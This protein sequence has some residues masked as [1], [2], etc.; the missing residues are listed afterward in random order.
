MPRPPFSPVDPLDHEILGEK[1]AA[2]GRLG[3]GLEKALAELRTF[4]A[5][6]GQPAAAEPVDAKPM[7]AE[8]ARRRR[9]LV[10]AAGHALWMFA[11]QREACGLRETRSLMRDFVVPPEVRDRMGMVLPMRRT[12]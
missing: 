6:H 2:L 4:D 1:A 12:V 5:A 8:T 3:R 10:A 7:N 11:V 9:E